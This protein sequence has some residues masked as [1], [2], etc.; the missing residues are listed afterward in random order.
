MPAAGGVLIW[1]TLILLVLGYF[2]IG[3]GS[4]RVKTFWHQVKS[5]WYVVQKTECHPHWFLAKDMPVTNKAVNIKSQFF[6]PDV[7]NFRWDSKDD[8]REILVCRQY[9]LSRHRIR[10]F[11]FHPSIIGLIGQCI[12]RIENVQFE[13]GLEYS[14]GGF[15]VVGN[16][17]S[18]C[19]H[20]QIISWRDSL[21]H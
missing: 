6:S 3:F 21:Q 17:G 11:S 1:G 12:P 5:N 15:S 19:T 10:I 2:S 18:D 9:E 7:S 4:S 13:N 20:P 14:G 8:L 16:L